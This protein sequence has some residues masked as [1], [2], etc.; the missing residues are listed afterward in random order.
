MKSFFV[1]FTLKIFGGK[2]T[3]NILQHF[4]QNTYPY[5]SRANTKSRT[6][7]KNRNTRETKFSKPGKFKQELLV[8]TLH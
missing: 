6:L 1:P 4:S 2:F 7:K 5:N 3:T 8:L